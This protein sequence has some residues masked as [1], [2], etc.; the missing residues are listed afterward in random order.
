LR[1]LAL[2]I[3]ALSQAEEL[4]ADGSV[5]AEYGK[6]RPLFRGSYRGKH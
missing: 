5:E 2:L 6:K 3:V 1:W 4:A